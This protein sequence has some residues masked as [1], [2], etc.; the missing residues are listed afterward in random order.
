M[1]DVAAALKSRGKSGVVHAALIFHQ[2]GVRALS[3]SPSG[4]L[5]ASLGAEE[6]NS[7]TVWD[8]ESGRPVAT[9]SA[10]AH[11]A[12]VLAWWHGRNDCLVT[13]GTNHVRC[14]NFNSPRRRLEP[15]DVKIPVMQREFSTIC[16]TTD[17]KKAFCGTFSGDVF[18]ISLHNVRLEQVSKVRFA[19]GITSL[20]LLS[21]NSTAAPLTTAAA[22]AN[23]DAASAYLIVGT[24]EG[25]VALLDTATLNVNATSVAQLAGAVTSISPPPSSM[26]DAHVLVGTNAGNIY[27]LA[28]TN[29][30]A[31][32]ATRVSSAHAGG[33][34][35]GLAFPSNSAEVFVSAAGNEIRLW[36]TKSP[37]VELLRILVPNVAITSIALAR[38]GSAIFSGWADGRLRAHLPQSGLLAFEILDAHIDAVSAVAVTDNGACILTGGRDGR[39]RVWDARMG[40]PPAVLRYS[41]KEH[42]KEVTALAVSASG[43]E[44]ISASGDGSCLVWNLR[45]GTR[46]NALFASTLF[47]GVAYTPDDSQVLTVGSDRRITYW[48]A[49]DC[50]AL[51][52]MEGATEEVSSG[53]PAVGSA[54]VHIFDV[55]TMPRCTTKL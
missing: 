27:E 30:M 2:G 48:D 12:R 25:A 54:T 9:A 4:M 45:R 24:G 33:G 31:I 29:S 40:G 35:V 13:A 50:T 39:V 11:P 16:V 5:L 17:N 44:A 8:L 15:T 52:I 19:Q 6:D 53:I 20:C 23:Y 32:K 36:A 38:D 49:S 22:T 28:V 46:C 21:H 7:L 43:E 55:D 10:H 26:N 14:W 41:W 37:N 42:R 34:I 3:F 1:W 47:R 18:E 51:R